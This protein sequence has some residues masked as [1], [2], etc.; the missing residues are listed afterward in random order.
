MSNVNANRE[1]WLC[2]VPVASICLEHGGPNFFPLL[3]S[4][5]PSPFAF[6]ST[7][8]FLLPH[9]LPLPTLFSSTLPS[10]PFPPVEVGVRG[11]SPQTLGI[12]HCRTRVLKRF[13]KKYLFFFHEFCRDEFGNLRQLTRVARCL[14]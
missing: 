12:L 8:P 1:L 11:S 6:P 14:L 5:L 10:F 13:W 4:L 3:F 7:P 2:W 9:P